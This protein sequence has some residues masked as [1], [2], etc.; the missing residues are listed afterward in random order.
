ML[1]FRAST[2]TVIRGFISSLNFWT[3]ISI[4]L[5]LRLLTFSEQNCSYGVPESSLQI[6]TMPASVSPF[7]L[8]EKNH[9]QANAAN[10]ALPSAKTIT[11]SP[12]YSP[13]PQPWALSHCTTTMKALYKQVPATVWPPP[14]PFSQVPNS[15]QEKF[16]Q[17]GLP[18]GGA[19]CFAQRYEGTHAMNWTVSF[20]DGYCNEI[21]SGGSGSYSRDAVDSLLFALRSLKLDRNTDTLG[22]RGAVGLV[23]GTENPWVECLLLNEGVSLVWTFEYAT[24]N[25]QHPR[26]KAKQCQL[27]AK[28]YLEGQFDPVD[29]IVSYSSLEHSGLGRYGDYLNPDG[30][31]EALAQAWCM[32]RPGGLLVLGVPIWC[33]NKG[34]IVFNAHRIY[35]YE[36]LAYIAENFE[37]VG[38]AGGK[39]AS[40]NRGDPIVLLRKPHDVHSKVKGVSAADFQEAAHTV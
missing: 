12:E 21:L 39:C 4:V 26:M 7:P 5:I 37:L 1:D 6:I 36:R 34:E 27:I 11:K 13:E 19:M 32:L 18:L 33:A 30:D 9:N 8:S 16:L 3:L 28:D 40:G 38:F 14:C 25:V 22:V 31:K 23:M 24:I 17:H 29:V 10:D 2:R 35:G 20:I 15:L